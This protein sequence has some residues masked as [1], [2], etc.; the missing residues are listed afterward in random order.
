[1]CGICGQ[2][3]YERPVPVL[4]RD[5]EKMA[6][7]MV[8]RG[9]D[10]EGYYV[11]GPLGLGFRRLSIIDIEGGHQP[12]SDEEG[13]VRVVFNGEI[14][15]FPELRRELE[16]FGY[17]FRT[18][19]DTEVIVLGYKQW[20]DEV[21]NRLNGMFG[22]AIWD[23]RKRRLVIARDPF[24]IKPIYY[25]IEGGKVLFGSEIRT[26][27]AVAK[28]TPEPDPTAINLFLRY[29]FTPSP[30]TV[31]K[32]IRKLAAGTMLI[33]EDGGY[34]LKRWYRFHPEPFSP[35]KTEGAAREELLEIYKRAVKRHLLSDVPLGLL[36]SGGI[37]SALLLALMN[38]YG[39]SWRTFTVGYGNVF[40]DDELAD[41]A[42]TAAV[43]GSKHTEVLLDRRTFEESLPR[44]VEFME[45]P[46]ATS[47]VL[48]MFFV[49][50]RARQD[51]K[52]AL[53]GQGPDELFGGYRR[54]LGTRYGPLWGRLP[55][56]VRGPISSAVEALPRNETLKRGVRSLDT[57]ER[58]RRYQQVLSL[59]P[60]DKVDGLFE[61]DVLPAAAGDEI[62]RSWE[63]FSELMDKTDEL[64]GLQFIE[65]RSTLPDEL[66][67]YGDKLSM[68]H[69]LEVRVPYLDKEVVE[70]GERL[71]AS[72]KVRNGGGKW[73]HREVCKAFLPATILRRKKRGF[74]TNV[75]DEWFRE[76]QSRKLEGML[77]DRQS[78]IFD[79]LRPAAVRGL[80]EQH[81]SG[82]SD[83][84]KILFSLVVLEEWLRGNFVAA[85]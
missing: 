44:V 37:D 68:A 41:A 16:S 8:H 30:Y 18:H 6:R 24:G 19:C 53:I 70:Y 25:K 78:H 64:G 23:E 33:F 71:P 34:R 28:E 65:L 48:P 54:H 7:S 55:N 26:I 36:L 57:P 15:N 22:L 5:I 56:W 77:L 73:L 27:L 4:R 58:L 74:A 10:D 3:N 63:E 20:G 75:V 82:A 9:P 76:A 49:C 46:V 52:V 2:F 40:A 62:L 13:L 84:H 60:G 31:F 38:L 35:A 21:F 81:R 17:V 67:M 59:L 79:Y 29:R 14:Y 32:G 51:V 66:L 72:F 80:L 11:D 45:E 39:S 47:S 69:S 50:E 43:F 1:M 61:A 83:H 12:M 42:Q 85:A